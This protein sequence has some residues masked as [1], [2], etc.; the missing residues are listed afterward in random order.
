M[1]ELTVLSFQASSMHEELAK[2][3]GT[4]SKLSKL[5]ISSLKNNFNDISAKNC[6]PN[7]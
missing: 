2:N 3:P 7:K 1:G 5:F 4:V 6:L